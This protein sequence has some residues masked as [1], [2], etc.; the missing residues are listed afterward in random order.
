MRQLGMLLGSM[1]VLWLLLALPARWIWGD[2]VLLHSV[3]ALSVCALP[4]AASLVWANAGIKRSPDML[5]FQVL[6]STGLRMAFVLGVGLALYLGLPDHFSEG[7]WV[8][9]LVFYMFSLFVEVCLVVRAKKANR[10]LNPDPVND[11]V[12]GHRSV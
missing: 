8:W 10:S 2:V 9:V 4:A 7:F 12:G 1:A 11:A 5:M 6:G 3:V